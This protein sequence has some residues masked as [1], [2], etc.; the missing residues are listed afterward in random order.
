VKERRALFAAHRASL[1]SACAPLLAVLDDSVLS[2]KL[3]RDKVR[4]LLLR[5]VSCLVIV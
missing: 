3:K 4:S 1:Q 2:D 5:R